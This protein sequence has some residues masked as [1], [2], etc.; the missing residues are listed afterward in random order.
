MAHLETLNLQC[1]IDLLNFVNKRTNPLKQ[2]NSNAK[3]GYVYKYRHTVI[4]Q[5]KSRFFVLSNSRDELFMRPNFICLLCLL[6]RTLN[7]AALGKLSALLEVHA[8]GH[9][10]A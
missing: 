1:N 6:V 4:N 2:K 10:G 7:A 8:V 9:A 5:Q 3:L